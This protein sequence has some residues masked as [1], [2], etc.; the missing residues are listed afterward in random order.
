MVE[1]DEGNQTSWGLVKFHG[2]FDGGP[3]GGPVEK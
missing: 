3:H 1:I 2:G